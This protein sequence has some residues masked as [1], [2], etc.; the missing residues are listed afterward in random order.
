VSYDRKI[1]QRPHQSL[2][3]EMYQAYSFPH[4]AVSPAVLLQPMLPRQDIQM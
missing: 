2:S 4:G 3:T 1:L